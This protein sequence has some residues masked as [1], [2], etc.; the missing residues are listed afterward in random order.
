MAGRAEGVPRVD[1]QRCLASPKSAGASRAATPSVAFGD[2]SP[3]RGETTFYSARL[4]SSVW[5]PLQV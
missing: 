3:S 1:R 4:I 5:P 2:I